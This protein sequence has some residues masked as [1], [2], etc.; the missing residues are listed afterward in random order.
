MA[1]CKKWCFDLTLYTLCLLFT[2]IQKSKL[3]MLE[4]PYLIL[5]IPMVKSAKVV[6]ITCKGQIHDDAYRQSYIR[7]LKYEVLLG[8]V[9]AKGDRLPNATKDIV[10][11]TEPL[12]DVKITEKTRVELEEIPYTEWVSNGIHHGEWMDYNEWME[13]LRKQY[14][15]E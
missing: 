2:Q 8:K 4:T 14:D 3:E 15:I 9:I 13:K 11:H 10:L 1:L 6:I 12:G 7:Q 5:V